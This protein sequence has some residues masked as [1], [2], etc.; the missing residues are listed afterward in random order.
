MKSRLSMFSP[1]GILLLVVL[2]SCNKNDDQQPSSS[3]QTSSESLLTSATNTI[4]GAGDQQSA[5]VSDVVGDGTLMGNDSSVCRIVSFSPSRLVF[6]HVKTVDFGTGCT[7]RDGITR[8]GKKMVM[9]YADWRIAPA[10]TLISE[11]TFS[12]FWLDSVNIAGNVRTYID[13][14]ATG[15][16]LQLKVV[17]NKTFTDKEGNT[18]TFIEVMYW[19]QIAGNE[20]TS[21][22][23]NVFQ[24][25]GHASGTG[26]INGSTAFTFN[27]KTDPAHPI[28]KMGNCEYRSEGAIS[29]KIKLWS[30]KVYD[31][32]LDYGN[33]DCDNIATISTNGGD[34]KTVTL[35][36]ISWPVKL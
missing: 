19:K 20:T 32:Y 7:G 35:P 34:A 9:V 16:V 13:S 36:L 2:M 29:S 14:A 15:G 5:E 18:T 11:T 27:A 26:V 23:D 3:L 12:D 22:K 28:I 21:R 33:G 24:L 8:S 30:G 4:S 25:T 1:A 6:P 31:E 17:T 10:G